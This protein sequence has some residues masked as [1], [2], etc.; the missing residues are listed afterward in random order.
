MDKCRLIFVMG[1]QRS[2]TN[3]LFKSLAPGANHAFNE[4]DN[5]LLFEDFLLRDDEVVR[6]ALEAYSGVVLAKPISET[7]RRNVV[8]VLEAYADHA[9]SVVWIYRDPVNC[10]ASHIER[11]TGF[12]GQPEAFATSWSARNLSVLEALEAHADRITIVRYEDLTKSPAMVVSLGDVL[13]LRV[14]SKFSRDRRNG[15]AELAK[16]EVT[17]IEAG[18]GSVLNALDQARSL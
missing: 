15:R 11:W 8:D 5:S 9:L 1:V 6:D 12:R 18:T 2:G 14:R 10:Y 4:S 7:K 17:A 13:G 3:A 16:A